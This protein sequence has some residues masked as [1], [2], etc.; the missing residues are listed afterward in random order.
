MTTL[1]S[2]LLD[3]ATTTPTRVAFRRKVLG[4]W[5][6]TTY[7]EYA[8]RAAA[9]GVG[10]VEL[11]VGPGEHVAI[12]S[13]NRPEWLFVDLAVQGIGAST[14]GLPPAAPEEDLRHALAGAGAMAVVVEDELQLDKVLAV[15]HAL[16]ALR[17]VI[18]LEAPSGI[19]ATDVVPLAGIEVAGGADP[20]SA[21]RQRV[22]ALDPSACAA[23]VHTAGATG[24][25]KGVRLSHTTLVAAGEVMATVNGIGAGD[26]VLSP[27]P[28]SQVTSRLLSGAGAL[29][30]GAAVHFGEAGPTFAM[31]LREVQPSVFLAPPRVWEQLYA[32][33]EFRI[34]DATRL[35]RAA[36]RFGVASGGSRLKS[37]LRWLL[38]HRMLREKLG[39]ARIRVALSTGAPIAP[40]VLEW[41]WAI[42]VPVREV[43][44]PAE[45]AG[46]VT[47]TPIDV[48]RP[49]TVGAAVAGVELG[50]D[51]GEV[52][53]RSPMTFLGYA[54][55][56]VR[57][58]GDASGWLHTGDLGEVSDDGYLTLTGRAA[59]VIEVAGGTRVAPGP[60][61]A[62][63]KVSPFVRDAVLVGA[64]R[65][66]L[67]ALIGIE[68]VTVSEFAS[69]DGAPAGS[70]AEMVRRADVVE[71]VEQAVGQVNADLAPDARITAFRLLPTELDEE[72]GL[73][74]STFQVRRP[75][76]VAQFGDLIE[77]MYASE[78]VR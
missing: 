70:V 30:A 72:G 46:L 5:E 55:M 22:E 2:R 60:I 65:P 69:R 67:T 44:G 43:Y 75:A 56:D 7:A 42:G 23:V 24:A 8:R 50:V 13:E 11:G 3:A 32:S 74:S 6:E 1:P 37:G 20:V 52:V 29:V 66:R 4:V 17:H 34:L 39:M 28:L 25:P 27:L 26:E 77:S 10:L 41:L 64:G 36:Y 73:L 76:V 63:L 38:L 57:S 48:R 54:G 47:V 18:V 58:T 40:T 61:E 35:K 78:A 33:T 12:A 9:I 15:R 14:V 62:Q 71:L 49:G 21:W 53:V 45:A 59:D 31:E 51:Q 19:E 16:P 68:P